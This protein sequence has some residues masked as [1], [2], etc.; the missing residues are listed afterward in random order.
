MF[1]KKKQQPPSAATIAAT[2]ATP[3]ELEAQKAFEQGITTLRD[4]I[5]PSSI[6]IQSSYFRLGTK[7]FTRLYCALQ[8]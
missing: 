4:F 3:A 7:Y 6:E 8:H 1:K 2:N 5:A